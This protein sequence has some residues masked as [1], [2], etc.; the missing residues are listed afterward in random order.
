MRFEVPLEKDTKFSMDLFS[1]IDLQV[2]ELAADHQKLPSQMV[3]SGRLGKEL[4]SFIKEKDWS[5]SG[6]ELIEREGPNQIVFKYSKEL[7]Q[8][9]TNGGIP[10]HDPSFNGRMVE[11][12]LG[13][14]T[15]NKIMAGYLSGGFNIER[16]VRPEKIVNL[17]RKK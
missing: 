17:T 14:E 15:A 10:M 12:A 4:Y 3:F 8:V 9:E 7:D 2:S 13:Q 16:K 1:L 11:G 5:F 6:F